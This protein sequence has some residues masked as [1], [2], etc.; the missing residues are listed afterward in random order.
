MNKKI[1]IVA[2]SIILAILL[3]FL[4]FNNMNSDKT[5]CNW[6]PPKGYIGPCPMNAG[7]YF[8]GRGCVSL[9]ACV[10]EKN[11][12]LVE[13]GIPFKTAQECIAAC[14]IKNP[15]NSNPRKLLPLLEL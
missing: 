3:I 15:T 2:L 14:T 13:K 12:E 6:K 1:L 8:D 7:W 10:D 5:G 11:Y 9:G 4:A